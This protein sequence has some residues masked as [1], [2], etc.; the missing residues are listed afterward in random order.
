MSL[1]RAYLVRDA[2]AAEFATVAA[3]VAVELESRGCEVRL[4][5]PLP[6]CSFVDLRLELGSPA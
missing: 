1:S 2:K 4:S 3:E 6:A 5:G